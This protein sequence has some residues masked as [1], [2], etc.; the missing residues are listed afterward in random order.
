VGRSSDAGKTKPVFHVRGSAGG[1]EGGALARG[2]RSRGAPGASCPERAA[3]PGGPRHRPYK[4]W[5]LELV[6]MSIPIGRSTRTEWLAARASGQSGRRGPVSRRTENPSHGNSVRLGNERIPAGVPRSGLI[7][8]RVSRFGCR[9]KLTLAAARRSLA[10]D[11]TPNG[12]RWCGLEWLPPLRALCTLSGGTWESS[13]SRACWSVNGTRRP[14]WGDSLANRS[15]RLPG[16]VGGG[17]KGNEE[18]RAPF[19]FFRAITQLRVGRVQEPSA[20][21]WENQT[22]GPGG[23]PPGC[24]LGGRRAKGRTLGRV[25]RASTGKTR[26]SS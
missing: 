26:E 14:R 16:V 9:L 4:C 1:S 6:F 21:A 7:E 15:G 3:P 25:V 22:E 19:G 24:S 23:N 5:V 17:R 18:G 20:M 12:P 13:S 2:R 8:I 10:L 11:A